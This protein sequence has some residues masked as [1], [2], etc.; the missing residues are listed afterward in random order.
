MAETY[1]RRFCLFETT[2]GWIG[3]AWS[4]AGISHLQL[5][6]RDRAATMRRLLQRAGPAVESPAE[7]V[8]TEAVAAIGRL[9][10]GEAVDLGALPLDLDGIDA[11]RTEIYAEARRVGF[12]ETTTY[13]ALAAMAGHPGKARETGEA[14]GSNPVPLIVPCHRVLAANGRL[15]GFS[16]PG[17]TETKR[18]LLGLEGARPPSPPGQSAFVF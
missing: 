18:R 6:E 14:M 17:G 12:G 8:A 1:D 15:G 10:R 5:P 2:L 4:R 9:A 7:G 13:G 3:I 16:A 11:F